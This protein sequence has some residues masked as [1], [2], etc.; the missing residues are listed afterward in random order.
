ML[1]KLLADF[2]SHMFESRSLLG[3]SFV[4]FFSTGFW[5]CFY[6]RLAR[7]ILRVPILGKGLS[8]AI[9]FIPKTLWGC[10]ISPRA[11]ISGGLCLPH[12]IGIVIGR[13]VRIGSGV[14]IY[15]H[16]T[17]G[18]SKR[19]ANNYP[20][21]GDGSILFAGSVL[22]GDISIGDGAVVGA[23][24]VVLIDVPPRSVAAGNPARVVRRELL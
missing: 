9:C 19:L 24:S 12:P 15:Q 10:Y 17:L 20:S 16:V 3:G 5:V 4:A 13:G 22:I 11:D 23:N 6:Y 18:S 21:V 2:K 1:L 14:R 8:F 7:S